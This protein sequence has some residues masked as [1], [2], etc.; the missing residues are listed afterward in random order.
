MKNITSRFVAIAGLMAF[1]FSPAA[2]ATDQY[3]VH[4]D[5]QMAVGQMYQIVGVYQYSESDRNQMGQT[6]TL[7]DGI[8]LE[9]TE[10]ILKVNS[11]GCE[12]KASLTIHEFIRVKDGNLTTLAQNGEVLTIECKGDQDI[13]VDGGQNIDNDVKQDMVAVM[14]MSAQQFN[15][16][17]DAA[18]GTPDLKYPLQSWPV[19]R[20]LA[21][22]TLAKNS[23]LTAD[24]VQGV[25][26]FSL[27]S[28][29]RGTEYLTFDTEV[30]LDKLPPIKDMPGNLKETQSG[31]TFQQTETVPEGKFGPPTNWAWGISSSYLYEGRADSGATLRVSGSTT[32]SVTSKRT[33]VPVV[34]TGTGN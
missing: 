32:T 5:R 10:K 11:I 13:Q 3:E 33:V 7:N 12:T 17:D 8:R 31:E 1:Y 27:L 25:T 4:L 28:Y 19:N 34:K 24:D 23:P 14:Q 2:G 15:A 6:A 22:Q 18:F 9:A 16:A 26:K 29:D 21:L 20:N 30:V